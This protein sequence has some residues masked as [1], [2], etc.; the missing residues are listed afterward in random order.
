MPDI[1]K[2]SQLTPMDKGGDVTDRKN[3]HPIL[4]LS[5]FAQIFENLVCKQP[6]SDVKKYA[7]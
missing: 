1:L 5:I 3:F 2:T 6:T 7:I 4:L